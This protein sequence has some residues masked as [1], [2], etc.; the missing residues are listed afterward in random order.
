M[1][2]NLK[3]SARLSPVVAAGLALCL[4]ASGRP[5]FASEQQQA[6]P[7]AP[8]LPPSTVSTQ[9]PPRTGPELQISADDAVKLALENNLGIRAERLG[10]Q[11]GTYGVSQAR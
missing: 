9:P 10:P 2:C 3:F 7:V 8:V 5:V 11:I 4:S 1:R 6:P